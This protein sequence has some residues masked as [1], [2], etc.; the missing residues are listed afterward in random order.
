MKRMTQA[1]AAALVIL[2]VTLARGGDLEQVKARML[3]RRPALAVLL[4]QAKAGEDNQ[5]YLAA[6]GAMTDA[7]Q[8]LLKDENA[9]RRQVYEEIAA[10][11]KAP[12]KQVGAKRAEAIAQKVKAGTWLQNAAGN[13]YQKP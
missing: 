6:R 5:G 12:V 4:A 3:A 7:E 13:W 10:R 9:E 8:K 1:V 11:T 2:G